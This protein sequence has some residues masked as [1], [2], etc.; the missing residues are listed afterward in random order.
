[1]TQHATPESIRADFQRSMDTIRGRRDLS[2]QARQVAIARTYTKTRDGLAAL[3]QAD[4]ERY[5]RQRQFL[6][7]K[8]FGN[9]ADVSGSNALSSRDARER[10]AKLNDPR[11]AAAAY[12]RAQRD[13]DRDYARAI[14]AHAADQA[15]TPILGSAWQPIV[16]QHAQSTPGLADAYQEL[17]D[18]RQPGT[19]M[20][21]SY[22][23]PMPSE[24]GRLQD[25]QVDQLAATDLT[26]HGDS[27]TAA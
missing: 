26:I 1:M 2:T 8:L 4:T 18:M 17:A 21:F 13:G 12:Q 16:Q 14:A 20:D 19:G 27:P 5:E 15:S 9:T 22:V 23:L 6:E 3:Q 25:H 24:L 10:A 11:E 7:R